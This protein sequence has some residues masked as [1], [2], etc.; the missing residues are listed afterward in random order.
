MNQILVDSSVW[1]D[2]FRGGEKSAPLDSLLDDGVVCTNELILTELIPFLLHQKQHDAAL[3]LQGIPAHA[4]L[5]DWQELRRLE[6]KNLKAGINKVGIPDLMIWLSV[7]EGK[8][9]LWSF[10]K[11]FKL[12]DALMKQGESCLYLLSHNK[13][14]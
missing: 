5:V 2:Y 3:L 10:D 1:I 9:K 14:S 13:K 8:Y 11:H 7:T 6:V 4:V 12:M